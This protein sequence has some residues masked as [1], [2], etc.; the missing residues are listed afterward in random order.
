MSK[1]KNTKKSLFDVWLRRK[2]AGSGLNAAQVAK[3]VKVDEGTVSRWLKEGRIPERTQ[4]AALSVLF[5]V[6]PDEIL[7]VTDP[8]EFTQTLKSIE[9]RQ[10]D[11]IDV[12]AQVPELRG[13]MEDL[14]NATPEL[15]AAIV[16]LVP[17]MEKGP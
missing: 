9:G 13:F 16:M 3:G 10:P 12:L 7:K 6:S 1:K 5:S 15:R 17:K 2:M 14:A 8:D 11:D 4:V